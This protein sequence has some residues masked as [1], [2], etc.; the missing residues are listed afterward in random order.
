MTKAVSQAVIR[1]QL[2]GLQQGQLEHLKLMV[3]F[4]IKSWIIN[5]LSYASGPGDLF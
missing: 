1:K 5:Q 3:V 2:A 4:C